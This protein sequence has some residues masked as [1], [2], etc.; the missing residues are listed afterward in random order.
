MWPRFN[1]HFLPPFLGILDL[2]RNARGLI[3]RFAYVTS[4]RVEGEQ[5]QARCV[6]IE[7]VTGIETETA[8]T[9][10]CRWGV[11]FIVCTVYVLLAALPAPLIPLPFTSNGRGTHRFAPT[12][13]TRYS[14]VLDEDFWQDCIFIDLIEGH[15]S[16]LIFVQTCQT[17]VLFEEVNT[18]NLLLSMC[19][20]EQ[21]ITDQM[22]VK[23][24]VSSFIALFRKAYHKTLC[25]ASWIQYTPSHP[26]SLKSTLT[27]G[28]HKLYLSFTLSDQKFVRICS[29]T[30]CICL[31]HLIHLDLVALTVM[32]PGEKKNCVASHC[33]VSSCVFSNYVINF[34]ERNP[35]WEANN[36]TASQE[37]PRFYEIQTFTRAP[38]VDPVPNHMDPVYIFNPQF[39]K[40][41][42]IRSAYFYAASINI[43]I[44]HQF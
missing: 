15:E 19:F 24:C 39:F 8:A 11:M 28:S 3:V 4:F 35:L 37:I 12:T 33:V 13:D 16:N 18:L 14:A 23:L 22:I 34:M 32:G 6:W 40:I 27:S 30:M 9:K 10:Y 5:T 2:I 7:G 25:W 43:E 42:L 36:C 17:T 20:V 26:F 38:P 44:C 1:I 31:T 29:F 41:C 21:L